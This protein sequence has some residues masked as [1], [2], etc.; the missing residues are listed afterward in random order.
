MKSN[1]DK[2]VVKDFGDEWTTLLVCNRLQ[3]LTLLSFANTLK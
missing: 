3:E 1:I 2:K